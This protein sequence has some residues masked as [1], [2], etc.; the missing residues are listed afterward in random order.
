MRL[1]GLWANSQTRRTKPKKKER[2][3]KMKKKTLAALAA[4]SPAAVMADS[5][6]VAPPAV[7]TAVSTLEEA[8]SGYAGIILPYI[9][10]VGLSFIGIAVVYLLFKV[11]KRFV[12]GK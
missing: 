8:A 4:V 12:S 3:N 11:F 7:T 10:A 6:F 5:T 9:A 2:Q 1:G